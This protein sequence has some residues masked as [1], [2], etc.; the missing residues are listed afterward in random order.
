[1]FKLNEEN[2]GGD[3]KDHS[4]SEELF[5][6][7]KKRRGTSCSRTSRFAKKNEADVKTKDTANTEDQK[8]NITKDIK[9]GNKIRTKIREY[10]SENPDEE[11]PMQ[12]EQIVDTDEGI[13]DNDALRRRTKTRKSEALGEKYKNFD[14]K[15]RS[16]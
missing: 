8:H 10:K 5:H 14:S 2:P 9:T 1:M 13:I 7:N 12:T 4:G 6:L 16:R 3:K 11:K 15:D